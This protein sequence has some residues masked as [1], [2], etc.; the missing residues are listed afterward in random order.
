MKYLIFLLVL[1]LAGCQLYYENKIV[2]YVEKELS[3]LE[4]ERPY[5]YRSIMNSESPEDI[6]DFTLRYLAPENDIFPEDEY[7]GLSDTFI[8]G[9][10]DCEERALINGWLFYYFFGIES[11]FVIAKYD[12]Y[13]HAFLNTTINNKSFYWEPLKGFDTNP[14][15]YGWIIEKEYNLAKFIF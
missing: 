1:I 14:L 12:N 5:V 7:M 13:V 11:K 9:G 6:L 10:C 4:I 2:D 15:D 3:I 8:V